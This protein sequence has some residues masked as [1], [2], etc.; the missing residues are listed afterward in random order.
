VRALDGFQVR[1]PDTEAN[2][3]A[4]GS[5]GT[6]DD[7]SPFSLVRVIVATARSVLVGTAGWIGIL[8]W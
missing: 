2:R 4:F 1:V 8:D 6:A 5:S 7:S 3:E